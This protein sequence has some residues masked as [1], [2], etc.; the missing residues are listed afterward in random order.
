MGGASRSTTLLGAA[1]GV[2]S[3]ASAADGEIAHASCKTRRALGASRTIALAEWGSELGVRRALC[4]AALCP[5]RVHWALLKAHIVCGD[6]ATLAA[7][8][9]ACPSFEVQSRAPCT[10]ELPRALGQLVGGG[11]KMAANWCKAE[12]RWRQERLAARL[13]RRVEVLTWKLEVSEH[14]PL[15]LDDLATVDKLKTA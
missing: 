6:S 11:G 9:V 13:F 5:L 12:A 1:A 2:T 7:Q 10:S 3:C 4:V 14:A 15:G 8:R